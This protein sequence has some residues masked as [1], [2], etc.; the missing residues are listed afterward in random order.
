MKKAIQ[1][2]NLSRFKVKDNRYFEIENYHNKTL[3]LKLKTLMVHQNND[4]MVVAWLG[5]FLSKRKFC[6]LVLTIDTSFIS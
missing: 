2:M 4:Q 3:K 6:H 5:P 1:N